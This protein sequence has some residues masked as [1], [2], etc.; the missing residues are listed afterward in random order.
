VL[1]PSSYS[2]LF[3]Y[4]SRPGAGGG[5][6]MGGLPI[7]KTFRRS[8]HPDLMDSTKTQ[9]LTYQHSRIVL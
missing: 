3:L 9:N 7:K 4:H 8:R 1:N 2:E 6:G 5:A